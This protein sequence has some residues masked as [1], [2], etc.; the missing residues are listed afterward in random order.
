MPNL[1]T[2]CKFKRKFFPTIFLG[3]L[4]NEKF[5]ICADY[6][7]H[8]KKVHNEDKDEKTPKK[9]KT[10]KPSKSS[11]NSTNEFNDILAKAISMNQLT[12]QS[13]ENSYTG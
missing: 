8:C 11:K 2:S 13:L 12:N 9:D 7:N 4:C 10:R 5:Q 3:K 1:K 6:T